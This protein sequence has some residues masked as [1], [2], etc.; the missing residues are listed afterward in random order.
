MRRRALLLALPL[1]AC[2]FSPVYGPGGAAIGLRGAVLAADPDTDITFAFVQRIEE[3]FG[4]PTTPRLALSYT[5]VTVEEALGIDGSD[6]ITRFNIEGR[7]A[8][9]V[10]P[11]GSDAVTLTGEEIAFTAYSASG[12]T[13]STLESERDAE[14]RLAVILADRVVAR[15]LAESA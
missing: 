14:R 12:S 5:L 8:W 1:A 7:L 2:G 10:S 4:A 11:I 13:I 15:L 3:R 6:N 9:A